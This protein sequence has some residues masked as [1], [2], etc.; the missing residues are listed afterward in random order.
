MFCCNKLS[1]ELSF[2][3]LLHDW[4]V[5]LQLYDLD[6]R[7]TLC[8]C[9]FLS[10]RAGERYRSPGGMVMRIR[11]MEALYRLHHLID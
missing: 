4:I 7:L 2:F 9:L 5:G 1:I 8:E 11:M 3:L 10:Q 6:R